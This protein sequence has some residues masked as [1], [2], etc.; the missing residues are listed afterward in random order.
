MYFEVL[1]IFTDQVYETFKS[2]FHKGPQ[3]Y[4]WNQPVLSKVIDPNHV[5]NFLNLKKGYNT[6]IIYGKKVKV[7]LAITCVSYWYLGNLLCH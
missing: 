2:I 4:S 7:L 5:T 1:A 3:F 6:T